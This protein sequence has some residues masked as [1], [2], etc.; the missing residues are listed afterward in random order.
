MADATCTF[1]PKHARRV[2]ETPR[3]QRQGYCSDCADDVAASDRVKAKNNRAAERQQLKD[4]FIA[5]HPE[6]VRSDGVFLGEAEWQAVAP[7]VEK[8]SD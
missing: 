3:E 2:L 6:L 5:S 7:P 1:N 8:A 4:E